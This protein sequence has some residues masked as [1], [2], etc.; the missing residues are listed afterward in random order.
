[1]PCMLPAQQHNQKAQAIAT[2]VAK[3]WVHKGHAIDPSLAIA[4]CHEQALVRTWIK[5]HYTVPGLQA[6]EVRTKDVCGLDMSAADLHRWHP[7]YLCGRRLILD[8]ARWTLGLCRTSDL[9]FLW[10][11]M[12]GNG[13]LPKADFSQG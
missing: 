10:D 11:L 8:F 12:L 7:V 6:A 3:E 4:N 2:G 1:M 9:S 5:M 13:L